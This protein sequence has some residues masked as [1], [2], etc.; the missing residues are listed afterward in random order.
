MAAS[1]P[2]RPPKA[3][4][5][6]STLSVLWGGF[7]VFIGVL[8]AIS[9][10]FVKSVQPSLPLLIAVAIGTGMLQIAAG[11]KLRSLQ[12]LGFW[13]MLAAV[14]INVVFS[15]LGF[16]TGVQEASGVV[17]SLL[18]NGLIAVYLAAKRRMFKVRL[19]T[20]G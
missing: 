7:L 3:V 14:I 18:V 2:V 20:S 9:S 11:F 6:I 5:F 8:G 19:N 13:I 12:P 1:Y 16:I 10:P 17:L 15:T 4:A